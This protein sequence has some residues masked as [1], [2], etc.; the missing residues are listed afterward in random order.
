M[1]CDDW[2]SLNNTTDKNDEEVTKAMTQT[3]L[4]RT[5]VDYFSHI[6]QN[7]EEA[8]NIRL[9]S[10]LRILNADNFPKSLQK[11]FRENEV[12]LVQRDLKAEKRC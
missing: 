6:Q 4:F 12:E 8:T 1:I 3:C 2:I 7:V 11:R 9:L 5:L 10:L